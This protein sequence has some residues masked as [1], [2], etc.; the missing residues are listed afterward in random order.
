MSNHRNHPRYGSMHSAVKT[1]ISSQQTVRPHRPI[2]FVPYQDIKKMLNNL[3]IRVVMWGVG[4]R[5]FSFR[6]LLTDKNVN[7][8]GWG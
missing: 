1:V 8:R 3:K 5:D 7:H 6:K 4:F 2:N